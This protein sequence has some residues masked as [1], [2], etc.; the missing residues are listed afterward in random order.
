MLEDPVKLLS[1]TEQETLYRSALVRSFDAELYEAVIKTGDEPD[2]APLFAASILET[3]EDQ[4][5]K[6]PTFKQLVKNSY[7]ERLP[8][9]RAFTLESRL[10]ERMQKEWREQ[11]K[12]LRRL[13]RE[14]ADHYW[15]E[16][17]T[18]ETIYHLLVADPEAAYALLAE[19]IAIA[20]KEFDLGRLY[21]LQEMLQ[22]RKPHLN[23]ELHQ[24]RRQLR[25]EYATRR[26]WANAYYETRTY[27]ERSQTKPLLRQLR[28]GDDF[29]L[30]HIYA[31]GGMG[32][33]M[34]LRSIIANHCVPNNWPVAKIDFDYF[35]YLQQV[36]D[37]PWRL[38]LTAADQFNN[39]LPGRP[40]SP[41]L[42]SNQP[43]MARRNPAANWLAQEPEALS[44][45]DSAAKHGD[46]IEH[47]S[48]IIPPGQPYLMIFD[49]MEQL[50][51]RQFTLEKLFE[52][53]QD[54]REISTNLRV[55]LSGRFNLAE[56]PAGS[57][58][59]TAFVRVLGEQH[60][61]M[62]LEPFT[63]A[64]SEQYLVDHRDLPDKEDLRLA[65]IDKSERNPFKLALL[66]EIV[67]ADPDIEAPTIAAYESADFAYLIERIVMRIREPWVRWVL[68]YGVVP[69]HLTERFVKAIIIPTVYAL[70][71]G[72]RSDD[73]PGLD[74][75][76]SPGIDEDPFSIATLSDQAPANL[77]GLLKEY[78]SSYSWVQPVEEL[79][80]DALS[81]QPE[82]VR[83]IRTLL[84]RHKAAGRD[85]YLALH[86][87]A[88]EYYHELVEQFGREQDLREA[89]YHQY[90]ANPQEGDSYWLAQFDRFQD[91]DLL[92]KGMADEVLHL[93][94]DDFQIGR[95][96][97]AR[98]AYE[99]AYR[100]LPPDRR[101]S[102]NVRMRI[103][104][105]LARA[106]QAQAEEI[107][108]Q[109]RLAVIEGCLLL[110][111]QRYDDLLS[112]IDSN[113][114]ADA[115]T[116]L[117][118]ALLQAH[119]LNSRLQFAASRRVFDQVQT[120][121]STLKR[122]PESRAKRFAA[123]VEQLMLEQLAALAW[124][125]YHRPEA[126]QYYER[127]L[128]LIADDAL[129]D[130]CRYASRRVQ[131][132]AAMGQEKVALAVGRQALARIE[133]TGAAGEGIAL[134]QARLGAEINVVARQP[135]EALL[136]LERVSG[137]PADDPL[138][139]DLRARVAAAGLKVSEA[140]SSW[141]EVIKKSNE[142]AAALR[143]AANLGSSRLLLD[144]CQDIL[145]A[146]TY[147]SQ[148]ALDT[149]TS[150]SVP[151][152]LLQAK[153]LH[154]GGKSAAAREG[155]SA[156]LEESSADIKVELLVN[157]LATL[158][159][160][161]I[162]EDLWKNLLVLLAE[163]RP[164]QR[165]SLL[166][167]LAY[168]ATFNWA[169]HRR[170]VPFGLVSGLEQLLLPIDPAL[171]DPALATLRLA[172]LYRVL[173][174]EKEARKQLDGVEDKHPKVLARLHRAY[175]RLGWQMDRLDQASSD[176]YITTRDRPRDEMTFMLLLEHIERL[177]E[178]AETESIR[179]LAGLFNL[180]EDALSAVTQQMAN[181]LLN[182]LGSAW[183][184]RIQRL[185]ESAANIQEEQ[186]GLLIR[187][188]SSA[189]ERTV[190]RGDRETHEQVN[191]E[192]AGQF[193][194]WI[195]K[196]SIP[197]SEFAREFTAD[198]Q[199]TS[200]LLGRLL[201]SQAAQNEQIRE[202]L[203]LILPR[204]LSY[205]P[206]EMAQLGDRASRLPTFFRTVV[207]H[208][209]LKR[210][211]EA[212]Q[213][214]V[215]V[216][217]LRLGS[218]LEAFESKGLSE[219]GAEIS[220]LYRRRGLSVESI[221]HPNRKILLDA[222]YQLQPKVLHLE[223]NLIKSRLGP[224]LFFGSVQYGEESG[225][226]FN[227]VDLAGLLNKMRGAPLIILDP[228]ATGSRREDVH[229][230]CLRNA[231]CAQLIGHSHVSGVIA[232]GLVD[233]YALD[234]TWPPIDFIIDSLANRAPLREFF[235]KLW[236]RMEAIIQRD[237]DDHDYF[238][239]LIAFGGTALFTCEPTR[240]LELGK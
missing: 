27:L 174:A 165:L 110:A 194:N 69:R 6:A 149:D 226:D 127:L 80:F 41:L 185:T 213:G 4:P 109:A 187:L 193:L 233:F 17:D 188:N 163:V 77:W 172:E 140:Q 207:R 10:R 58:E 75:E 119:V 38:L 150:R 47:F 239:A 88:L 82:V 55:I 105:W 238:A 151:F 12:E 183:S 153:L 228:P 107:V 74:T 25:N 117:D 212:P 94:A 184:L 205:L 7:I 83:P 154:L 199:A 72:R 121:I 229:Q 100:T 33:T 63:A 230:L 89:I 122:A 71:E 39:Q 240:I 32:K 86:R 168:C 84:L 68:R 37:Q 76:I 23:S 103:E 70:K 35:S 186:G 157:L 56:P 209:P 123:Q 90:R 66:A 195:M 44:P 208:Y 169:E 204:E 96:V 81:F 178:Y 217:L 152:Q 215:D 182:R 164:E 235:I 180:Q 192:D 59:P 29:W 87:A 91:D 78:A 128:D 67:E 113:K 155:L 22:E 137:P 218:E 196:G 135:G 231:F 138:W 40:F 116:I 206:W 126:D 93:S 175:D 54:M 131:L 43:Y 120:S 106:R 156:L 3:A 162:D 112:L 134:V 108:G 136:Q 142:E 210:P 144:V 141:Q 97:L 92:I 190:V 111:G 53:L 201:F 1:L 24:M 160:D 132:L 98:A 167:D 48:S 62:M 50:R 18:L 158:E 102:E 236:D 202:H 214:D 227:P 191:E 197:S 129:D 148:A 118:F 8:G 14:L 85:I 21:A 73:A 147:L 176:V 52:L 181:L 139:W 224:A 130:I 166:D 2:F 225:A 125:Q 51:H 173:G 219:S 143:V 15:N 49:T 203:D 61:F 114:T 65:I 146:N 222:L 161:D 198:W 99:L 20:R 26:L 177:Q 232:T 34:Y 170:T 46:I 171:H 45:A 115:R 28:A 19:K 57:E 42:S 200:R 64:E 104:G 16:K 31:A 13:S 220:D 36:V 9:K 159:A 221:A 133:K 211:L 145:E 60:K 95:E 179:R 189:T 30:L 237:L 216:L 223:A 5:Q 79:D 101:L 11:P 124:E 234:W